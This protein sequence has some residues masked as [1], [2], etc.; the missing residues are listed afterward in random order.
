[1][2]HLPRARLIAIGSRG[3]RADR[4]DVDARPA[5]I[6]FQVIAAIRNNFG[7]DAAI[8]H[9]QRA[10]AE[11]FT[12]NSHAAIT[13]NAARRIVKHNRRPLLFIDMHFLFAE[14]ALAP[15]RSGTPCPAVRIRR[16]CRRPGNRAGD[17]STEIRA[18]LCVPDGP[19]GVGVHDHAL[20]YGQACRPTCSL[21]IFSTSTR[22]MRQA[23]CSDK[24]S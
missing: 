18:C 15:P 7:R 12:A 10:D 13:E 3:Q 14:T 19:G 2:L 16:P 20:R 1:M 17:W 23:A 21:G 4:A 9:A 24:P 6:A 5:F 8:S 22:H 11:A